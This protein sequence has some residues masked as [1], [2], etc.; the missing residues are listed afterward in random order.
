MSP[1]QSLFLNSYRPISLLSVISKVMEAVVNQQLQ[2]YILRNNLISHRQFGFRPG[3]STADL[4]NILCQTWNNYLDLREEVCVI[5]LD[6]QGAFDKVWHHGLMAKL[7]S[8]GV[9]GKLLPWLQS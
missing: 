1:L 6:I 8:R 4:L 9:T 5:A 7:Y 2:R 3:H